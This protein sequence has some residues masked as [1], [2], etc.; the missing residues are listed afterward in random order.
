MS[1]SIATIASGTIT[2]ESQGYVLANLSGDGST[3]AL[4]FAA[5]SAGQLTVSAVADP[6]HTP[7]FTAALR[8]PAGVVLSDNGASLTA[9]AVTDQSQYGLFTRDPGAT[10]LR[11]TSTDGVGTSVIGIDGFDFS[12]NGE[13]LAIEV[14]GPPPAMIAD[15]TNGLAD[16]YLRSVN[17]TT[18]GPRIGAAS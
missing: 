17:H 3:V 7:T 4:V 1:R 10:T 8:S 5:R 12:G 2:H 9:R 14:N 6:S 18:T 13:W 16:I 15:D 11:L